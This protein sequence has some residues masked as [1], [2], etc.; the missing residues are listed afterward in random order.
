[1]SVDQRENEW[2]LGKVRIY[3]FGRENDNQWPKVD[4]RLL[5]TGFRLGV[6]PVPG[7]TQGFWQ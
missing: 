3:I 5:L 7:I 1:M 4:L 2:T 6:S